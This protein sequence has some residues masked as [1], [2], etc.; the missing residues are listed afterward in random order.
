MVPQLRSPLRIVRSVSPSC[1]ALGALFEEVILGRAR[2]RRAENPVNAAARQ[3]LALPSCSSNESS[4]RLDG[5]IRAFPRRSA[6]GLPVH[7][8]A[9]RHIVFTP[10]DVPL[11]GFLSHW[12]RIEVREYHLVSNNTSCMLV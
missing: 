2:L 7:P 3:R 10:T 11:R 4:V 6:F 5:V 1:F 12:E 9:S 8:M